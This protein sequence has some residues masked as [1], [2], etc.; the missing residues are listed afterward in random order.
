MPDYAVKGVA[1]DRKD[2]RLQA[3]EYFTRQGWT[4]NQA[5]GLAANLEKESGFDPKIRGDGGKA[6][7]IAQWH[8]DRQAD[9]EKL[10]KKNIKESSFEEQ[11]A[12][13]NY[14]LQNKE[15]AAGEQ[16]RRSTTIAEATKAGIA[17]ERPKNP[18][19]ELASRLKIAQSIQINVN[20]STGA[21]INANAA[22]APGAGGK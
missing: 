3:I 4:P 2:K 8:P 7:G 16:L 14:E 13:V 10:F 1:Q 9:F 6:I 19:D 15:K 17:Y 12:F 21:D 5:I 20:T 18:D 11:L 22:A